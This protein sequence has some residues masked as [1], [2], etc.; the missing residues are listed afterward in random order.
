MKVLDRLRNYW[1]GKVPAGLGRKP[2]SAAEQELVRLLMGRYQAALAGGNQGNDRYDAHLAR[3]RQEATRSDLASFRAN[4]NS[5]QEFA[6]VETQVNLILSSIPKPEVKPEGDPTLS[7]LGPPLEAILGD[8]SK[9]MHLRKTLER[10]LRVCLI[11]GDVTVKVRWDPHASGGLGDVEVHLIDPRNLYL[12]P[13]AT[14]WSDRRY[15]FEIEYFTPEEMLHIFGE[16]ARGLQSGQA[17]EGGLPFSSEA[18]SGIGQER[19]RVI[20]CWWTCLET[21][22]VP[23]PDLPGEPE[24]LPLDEAEDIEDEGTDVELEA[25][26]P[27]EERPPVQNVTRLTHPTGRVTT[28]TEEGRLLDDRANPYP[29]WPHVRMHNYTDPHLAVGLSEYDLTERLQ[30]A[31]DAFLS[32]VCDHMGHVGNPRLILPTNSGIDPDQLTGSFGEVLPAKPGAADSIRW[33]EAAPIQSHIFQFP[34]QLAQLFD[35][36]T[37]V[38]EVM[39]GQR[40]RG[41]ETYA[42]LR[43]LQESGMARLKHKSEDFDEAY[44]AILERVLYVIQTRYDLPRKMALAGETAEKLRQ[45]LADPAQAANLAAAARQAGPFEPNEMLQFLGQ[46]GKELY[47][48]YVGLGLKGAM[49]VSVERGNMIA[50]TQSEVAA[51]ALD[52]HQRGLIDQLDVL[53]KL[54]W[55]GRQSTIERMSQAA[56]QQAR[57]PAEP[58][59]FQGAPN[60]AG[61][62]ESEE[63]YGPM[64]A[65]AENVLL[66]SGRLVAVHPEDGPEHAEVHSAAMHQAPMASRAVFEQHIQA[67]LMANQGGPV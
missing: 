57:Q 16:R 2:E 10:M 14:S 9:R 45:L 27:S 60:M 48:Q 34:L 56:A 42:T 41:L 59:P 22:K 28:F 32:N 36:L 21:E 20:R 46:S 3:W 44:A 35:R 7:V 29:F 55:P 25:S 47:F 19:I 30:D 17:G 61:G 13:E 15:L 11:N 8:W 51:Q 67:H 40:P 33:F 5:G 6:N 49:K 63:D 31:I 43:A 39:Q 23:V 52:L 65:D 4:L 58:Q 54:K 38:Q 53:E 24:P 26:A 62:L 37:G 50:M 66:A 12:D 64:D 18:D 1:S